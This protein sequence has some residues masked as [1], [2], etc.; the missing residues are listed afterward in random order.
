MN[1]PYC[2]LEVEQAVKWGKRIIPLLHVEEID[3]KTWKARNPEG[4][5]D[6][7]KA[8]KA[9][10]KHSHFPNMHPVLRKINWVYM[11][12]GDDFEASFQNLLNL[13]GHQ[14]GYVHQHTVLL[15][16]ALSWERQQK[17]TR[18]LLTGIDRQQAE[19]WLKRRFKDEQAPCVPTALHGEF[20]TESVK[21]AQNR[22]TQVF[23]CHDE[24]DRPMM[25]RIRQALHRESFTVWTRTDI[26]TGE[27]VQD[28][29][30]RGIEAA[31]NVVYLLSPQAAVS[32]A[33]QQALD[34]AQTLNKRIVPV[35]MTPVEAA[36]IPP[37]LH[38]LQQIDWTGAEAQLPE[39]G[40]DELL[41]VL[42]QD[43]AYYNEHKV[44]LVKALKWDRQERNPSILLRGYNLRHADAWLKVGQTRTQHP[45]TA[46]QTEFIQVSLQQPPVP[47]LDVFISYSSAD[48]DFARTL[49]DELQSQGKLTWFD[50]ES[51]AAGT[52]DFQKEIYRGIASS[53]NF[54]FILSPQAVNSTYC[55]DEVDYAAQLNKRIVTV[56]YQ[57]VDGCTLHPELAKVQWL[58]F[59]LQHRDFADSF[60]QL[61]RTLETDRDYVHSHTQWSQRAIAWSQQ[62]QNA[63]LLLRG[64]ECEL[65]GQWLT[66]AQ[67]TP[68][69]PRVT[70]GQLAFITAS[71]ACP[72]GRNPT[73]TATGADLES[74]LGGGE[75]P[76][77]DC[78]LDQL[79]C[80]PPA[81]PL[82]A[83]CQGGSNQSLPQHPTRRRVCMMPCNLWGKV[84]PS[85]S[86]YCPPF[87]QVCGM[88][89]VELWS[90]SGF[91]GHEAAIWSVAFSPDGQ[92]IASGGFDR[93][94]RLWDR[95][96]NPVTPPFEGHTD[97]IWS[98]A[99]SPEGDAIA[100]ASSD[101]TVRLWNLEGNLISP[102]F[103]GHQGHV[104]AVAFSPDGSQIVSGD[105][106]GNLI[107]WDRQGKRLRPPFKANDNNGR[108]QPIQ[109]GGGG[110]EQ[111]S[112]PNSPIPTFP[113][114]S[115][116]RQSICDLVRGL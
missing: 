114:Q 88:P 13:L 116:P 45:P 23:L 44:L 18:Q 81:H 72:P 42:R 76:A 58:D 16:Q 111:R 74:A 103:Q 56:L 27:T 89:L 3:Y 62:G 110:D 15:N 71:Q 60:K 14:K 30:E 17:Q 7:W 108:G 95:E 2:L 94:I 80:P 98:V 25:V 93:T 41:R 5:P 37:M 24:S 1:S 22:M 105:Q 52:A 112:S 85:S 97:D 50:Q 79:D 19:N 73:G 69:I 53:D 46:L 12:E 21:N 29:I 36:A 68:K 33:C 26:Q 106:W 78:K 49:N 59:Q 64:S 87:G 82:K 100:S 4:T 91:E 8:Y 101:G 63:D 83:E 104:K 9:A 115:R 113:R 48:A 96:G 10:G 43:A 20:I 90:V 32:Q 77:A 39:A 75:W 40:Q 34:Y 65:A 86:S 109:T 11:R 66:A 84:R 47:S 31:D 107:L 57:S 28:A 38:G 92:L 55:A 67:Q 6:A 102:P 54:L 99:F 51:I 70:S 61:I 35:L